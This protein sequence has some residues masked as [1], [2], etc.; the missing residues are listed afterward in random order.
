MNH[1]K[2]F[3]EHK[4]LRIDAL[5]KFMNHEKLTLKIS[6]IE[7]LNHIYYHSWELKLKYHSIDDLGPGLSIFKIH[8]TSKTKILRW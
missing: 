6:R 5:G 1:I 8:S 3:C 2:I 7:L 4:F